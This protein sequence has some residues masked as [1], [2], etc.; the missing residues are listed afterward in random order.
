VA[1]ATTK[2]AANT[3]HE[4]YRHPMYRAG[5][6]MSARREN[7]IGDERVSGLAAG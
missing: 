7:F 4:K 1:K 5:D 6:V 3:H 2:P